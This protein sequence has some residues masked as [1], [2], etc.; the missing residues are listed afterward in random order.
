MALGDHNQYI[1][2]FLDSMK[3]RFDDADKALVEQ[4]A[5]IPLEYVAVWEAIS[6]KSGMSSQLVIEMSIA[7]VEFNDW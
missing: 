4:S 7:M 6:F 1:E 5:S 3:Q 2:D